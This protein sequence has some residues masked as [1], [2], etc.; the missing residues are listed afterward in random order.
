S[1]CPSNPLCPVMTGN[2]GLTLLIG[3][4]ILA[5][6]AALGFRARPLFVAIAAVSAE[7]V[8]YVVMLWWSRQALGHL[9][10][11]RDGVLVA[12]NPMDWKA[13]VVPLLLLGLVALMIALLGLGVARLLRR[14]PV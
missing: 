13:R 14:G 1:D 4:P 6:I 11:Q 5:V 9:P 8:A 2:Q 10:G 3:A 7:L 12:Y